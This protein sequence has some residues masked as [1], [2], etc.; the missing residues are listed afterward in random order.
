MA[1]FIMNHEQATK[2]LVDSGLVTEEQLTYTTRVVIDLKY[3]EPGRIYFER[4]GDDEQIRDFL[5]AGLEIPW[6]IER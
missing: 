3:G 2:M 1:K 6:E 5:K 4:Y